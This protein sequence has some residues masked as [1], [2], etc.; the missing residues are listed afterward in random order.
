MLW[1]M[2][3][4]STADGTADDPT[5]R[6]CIGFASRAGYGGIEVVNLFAF[7][8]TDPDALLPLP[9]AERVGGSASDRVILDVAMRCTAI[10]CGWGAIKKPLR[11]RAADVV[12]AL[13]HRRLYLH[14]LGATKEG[15][16]RHPLFVPYS[17]PFEMFTL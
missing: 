17:T 14:C 5:I 4:P 7:R 12:D 2:L 1:L 3:N 16:P 9:E 11:T 6:K 15:Q 8:S 10:V 13:R